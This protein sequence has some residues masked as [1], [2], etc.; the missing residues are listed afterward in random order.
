MSTK[1]EKEKPS[2]PLA[3]GVCDVRTT[4]SSVTTSHRVRIFYPTV[5]DVTAPRAQFFPPSVDTWFMDRS[6]R[7]VLRFGNIPMASVF[8]WPLSYIATLPLPAQATGPVLTT[9]SKFPV[10]LFTHGLGGAIGNYSSFCIDM[11]SHGWIVFAIEH[12]DGSSFEALVYHNDN[13][14]HDN[15][16]SLRAH[17]KTQES[18]SFIPYARSDGKTSIPE[19][20]APQLE[21]QCQELATLMSLLSGSRKELHPTEVFIPLRDSSP[22]PY[23]LFGQMDLS[24]IVVAGH[25]FGAATALMY[26][27]RMATPPIALI[28]MDPWM[29]PLEG[30]VHEFPIPKGTHAVFIDMDDPAMAE[31]MPVRKHVCK[32]DKNDGAILDA[33]TVVDGLHND[34]SDFPLRIPHWIA[35][36]T[37]LTRYSSDPLRLLK[38]QNNAAYH[39]LRGMKSWTAFTERVQ[40]GQE[41]SLRMAS[42]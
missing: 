12:A 1:T 40:N 25:S 31:N 32:Q 16:D 38:A 21:T 35:A 20:R 19:F 36:A 10:M 9:E 18:Y 39:F 28:C 14:N 5:H 30:R 26:A 37:N 41:D 4:G 13:N 6:V 23:N 33:I 34:S 7:S 22:V 29:L 15:D 3:V 11:A 27:T 24:H 2:G 42:V 8:A 17:K